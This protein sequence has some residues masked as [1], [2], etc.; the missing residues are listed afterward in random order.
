MKHA[1]FAH[2]ENVSGVFVINHKIKDVSVL[3]E[4]SFALRFRAA[5]SIYQI[6]LYAEFFSK[7]LYDYT[8]L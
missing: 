4:R 2:A 6:R 7:N 8:T 3:I 5:H 1:G